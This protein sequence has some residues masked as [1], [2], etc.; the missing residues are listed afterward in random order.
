MI[1][2][3]YINSYVLNLFILQ[4]DA[5]INKIRSPIHLITL[6]NEMVYHNKNLNYLTNVFDS[7]P[8]QMFVII[9]IDM[10]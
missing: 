10:N 2:I 6:F 3:S 7:P 8:P 4:I 1:I 9:I 5:I